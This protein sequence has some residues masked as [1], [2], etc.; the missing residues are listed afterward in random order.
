[1]IRLAA[2]PVV[3]LLMCLTGCNQQPSGSTESNV[4]AEPI[5]TAPAD[6]CADDYERLRTAVADT[7][8]REQNAL[9]DQY[10]HPVEVLSFF[11]VEP[12]HTVVEIWPSGG[13]WTEILA[14]YVR[15]CGQY[16]AAG[17][18]LDA[19]R[20]PGWRKRIQN[21]Y[22]DWLANDPERFDQVRV[23]GLSIPERPQIAEAGS[24]D[25][26]LTFRNV[27][28][29]MN[30]DYAPAVFDSMYAA[31]KPGGLLGLVEHRA[32]QGTPLEQ[33]LES[34]Y[35]TEDRVVQMAVAAGFE[36]IDRSEI[37][38]NPADTKDH[39]QGVWSLPPSY[40]GGEETVEQFRPIGES[41]R[42]TLLF[43][44]PE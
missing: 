40:R 36:L 33:M 12:Q 8:R 32:E 22:N 29:W 18:A 35:V 41:D 23:T 24:A 44:K 1:M 25:R 2:I 7:R 42:M 14:P 30:G 28:N 39:P 17:F 38:A 13:W 43:R 34:G 37:N 21:D 15:N 19:N 6:G 20:T 10:R 9:R 11:Q 3:V 31:L 16:I 5:A 4:E 26:V 27:H